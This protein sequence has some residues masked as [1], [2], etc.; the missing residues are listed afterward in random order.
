MGK[1]QNRGKILNDLTR[2]DSLAGVVEGPW[3]SGA[4]KDYHLL[5]S[6][7]EESGK[8]RIVPHRVFPDRGA[9]AL[10]VKG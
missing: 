2:G 6:D 3:D 5:G 4:G 7:L 9:R 1:K 8:E 10:V